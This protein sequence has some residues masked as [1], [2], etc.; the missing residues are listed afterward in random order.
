MMTFDVTSTYAVI[1]AVMM[2]VLWLQVTKY[3]SA[4]GISINHGDDIALAE[5][6][7]RHGNFIEIVPMV[8]ILMALSEAAGTAPLYLHAAGILL[9]AGRVL[10]PF[11]LRHDNAAAMGRILGNTGG[12]LALLIVVVT[13]ILAK[14]A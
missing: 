4:T 14:L 12:L 3:R 6:I 5:R 7:R 2:F 11:G 1:L 8:L 13:L 9:V 10:H